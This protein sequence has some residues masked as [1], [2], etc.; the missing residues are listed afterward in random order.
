[1]PRRLL[2]PTLPVAAVLMLGGLAMCERSLAGVDPTTLVAITDSGPVVGT[3]RAHAIEFRGIPYAAPPVGALR[4]RPPQPPAPW[5]AARGAARFGSACP[6]PHRYGLTD[7]SLDEDCLTLNVSIPERALEAPPN[8]DPPLLPVIVWIH[9]GAFVGG[10]SNLYRLDWLTTNTFTVVVSINYRLGVL[11]FMPHAGFDPESNG[12]YGIED[13]RMALRW[14]QRNIEAFG[15][16]P[17][18]VTL[19]G[20]S[21][22]AGSICIHLSDPEAS[23]GL[24]S[25]A[26]LLSAACEHVLPTVDSSATILGSKVAAAVG[27]RDA[28][29]AADCLR[30]ASVADLMRAGDAATRGQT[31]AFVPTVGSKSVPRQPRDAIRDGAVLRVPLLV[32]TARDEMRLYVAY[33]EQGGRHT[34]AGNYAD[35]LREIFGKHAPQVLREYPLA[36]G[37]SAPARLGSVLSDF[38]PSIP[39]NHCLV[40]ASTSALSRYAPAYEFEFADPNAP[41]L[42][43]GIRATPDPGFPLGT[44][45]SAMLSYLFPNFSN[46]AKIDG[47]VPPFLSQLTGKTLMAAIWHFAERGEPSER[48]LPPWPAYGKGPTVMRVEPNKYSTFDASDA[49]H[50]GFWKKQYPDILEDL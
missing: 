15:G 33:Q 3:A 25:K 10:S 2:W 20:E 23:R 43:V 22:G 48:R 34:T 7:E 49:H 31:L 26:V 29:T 8:G 27:C 41:A 36:A 30:A 18:N 44:V 13:Q 4:F 9:G 16:D 46:T 5:K 11:G 40:L 35:R 45:H 1:M 17:K 24:F 14:V 42:G 37:D 28:A 21:A 19:A 47:P 6:Q 50:C 38:N 12:A 39:I 32:G